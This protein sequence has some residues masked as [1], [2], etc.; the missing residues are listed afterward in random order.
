VGD[1][2]DGGLNR[3]IGFIAPYIFT[4][5]DYRQCSAIADLNNSQFTVV[6]SLG[7]SVFI[8]RI[9]ATDLLQSHCHFK[10]HMESSCYR[11]IHLLPLFCSCQ[12][13]RLNSIQFLCSQA[14]IPAR[15]RLETRLFTSRLLF[16][17]QLYS[18]SLPDASS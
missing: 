15:W 5:G 4:T 7:F 2:Q 17:T 6:H 12:F 14:H 11:L 10:S 3:M 9:L 18:C 16:S 8:C 1:L 13:R